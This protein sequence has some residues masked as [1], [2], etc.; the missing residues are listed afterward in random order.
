MVR[1]PQ[2]VYAGAKDRTE[3]GDAVAGSYAVQWRKINSGWLSPLGC[4]LTGKGGIIPDLK[5]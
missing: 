5:I 3:V 4:S 1:A 2:R